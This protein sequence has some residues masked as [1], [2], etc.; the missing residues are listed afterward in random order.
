MGTNQD[1]ILA[2]MKSMN[3]PVSTVEIT[4]NVWPNLTY[5]KYQSRFRTVHR[6][7]TDLTKYGLVKKGPMIDKDRT[8]VIL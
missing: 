7:L 1:K 6:N 5:Q 4:R 2:F 3:R 8:W